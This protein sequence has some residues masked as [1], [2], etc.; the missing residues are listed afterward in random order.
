MKAFIRQ[1][2]RRQVNVFFGVA[3]AIALAWAIFPP[4]Y[5]HFSGMT[6]LILSM[7]LT[8]WYWLLNGLFIFLIVFGLNLVER[9]RGE[10]D[11][12]LLIPE[13]EGTGS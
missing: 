1:R 10:L 13:E 12:E 3:F 8:I 4:L 5:L 11:P 9:V 6:Y 7:P 2:S